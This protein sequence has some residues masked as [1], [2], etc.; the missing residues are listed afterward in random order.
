[1]NNTTNKPGGEGETAESPHIWLRYATQFTTGG[2]THTI[3]MGIPVPLGATA[4]MRAKLIREAQAGM[5]QLSSH[6]ES[7]VAQMLQRNQRPQ[8]T[9]S[10]P[11]IPS[12][13]PA[14]KPPGAASPSSIQLGGQ[15]TR[16]GG[17]T[18]PQEATPRMSNE[19]A[20][21]D[22]GVIVPPIRTQHVGASMPL[23]PGLPGEANSILSLT[24]FLRVIKGSWGLSHQ[25]AKDLLQVRTLDGMN[26]RDALERLQHLVAQKSPGSAVANQ[27][28]QEADQPIPAQRPSSPPPPAPMPLPIAPA[29]PAPNLAP[30]RPSSQVPQN[31]PS[32][33]AKPLSAPT[34]PGPPSPL[35]IRPTSARPP[36]DLSTRGT[37]SEKHPPYRFDEEDDLEEDE[38]M[39]FDDVDE[40]EARPEL[41]A[42]ELLK[43][44]NIISK[45]K[46][47]HGSSAVSP[48]RLTVLQNITSTQISQEQ[49][50]ELLQAFWGT[51]TPKKLKADQVEELISWAKED[52]FAEEVEAVL[53]VLAEE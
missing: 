24:Q 7:R 25:Q 29:R 30:G 42:E 39:A 9:T 10:A 27:K 1:M 41:S 32:T 36:I 8:S 43:A 5:D 48:G 52:E 35:G 4:E 51:P 18:P 17:S 44:R 11:P 2:R 40:S 12:A 21:K 33:P 45:M 6:V 26:L 22:T 49:L 19:E 46:D 20:Q 37:V 16:V 13:S 3:E 28:P 14:P 47:V 38:D 53:T 34:P 15:A 23:A 50:Q 31:P